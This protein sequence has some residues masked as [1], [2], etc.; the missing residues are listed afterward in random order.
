MASSDAAVVAAEQPALVS[1][2]VSQWKSCRSG[3]ISWDEC[4]VAKLA[5]DLVAHL[6]DSAR[7]IIDDGSWKGGPIARLD[8]LLARPS[9]GDV[10][11]NFHLLKPVL[12]HSP[13]RV[14]G[15]GIHA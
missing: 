13:D 11:L 8:N 2:A 9:A 4:E 12:L 15:F 7:R 5:E 3:R 14:P 6:P 1:R 10:I